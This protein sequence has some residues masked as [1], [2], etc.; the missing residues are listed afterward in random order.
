MKQ[1]YVLLWKLNWFMIFKL[2]PGTSCTLTGIIYCSWFIALFFPNFPRN[3]F[4]LMHVWNP[5]VVSWFFHHRAA[6]L[7]SPWILLCLNLNWFC[8]WNPGAIFI[9]S[10]AMVWHCRESVILCIMTFK[11]RAVWQHRCVEKGFWMHHHL[12][13][14]NYKTDWS[15]AVLIEEL[16]ILF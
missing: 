1:F 13:L 7:E 12:R 4:I 14:G 10:L 15:C 5:Q 9:F 8:S 2:V 11:A 3:L 16:N 6:W